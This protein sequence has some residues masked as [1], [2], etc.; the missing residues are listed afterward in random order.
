MNWIDKIY[1]YSQQVISHHLLLEVFKD[2]KRPNDKISECLKKGEIISLRR[3]LYVVSLPFQ[4]LKPDKFQLANPIYGPSYIS[5]ESALAFYNL[6]PE[7]VFST[8]SVTVKS[9]KIFD[10]YFGRFEYVHLP[11]PYYCYGIDLIQLSNQSYCLIALKEKAVL[12]KIVTTSNLQLQSKFDVEQY[13]T[14][15]LRINFEELIQLATNL[16]A[17]WLPNSPKKKSIEQLIQFIENI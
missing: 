4:S 13:L 14:E 3:G 10:N 16:I 8:S 12:D 5:L 6:I 2:Y 9:S 7:K 17:T 15:N 1:T 11:Y